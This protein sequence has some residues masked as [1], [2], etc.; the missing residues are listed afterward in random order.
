MENIILEKVLSFSTCIE[1]LEEIYFKDSLDY[2]LND[3]G[4][5]AL[6]IIK[7]NGKIKTM[8]GLENFEDTIDVDIYAPFEQIIEKEKFALRIEKMDHQII[9][10][11]LIL[12]ITLSIDGFKR[13]SENVE[14]ATLQDFNMTNE[15]ENIDLETPLYDNEILS[16]FQKEEENMPVHIKEEPEN[17]EM[18]VQ[19]E[20]VKVVDEKANDI[21][22]EDI[23]PKRQEIGKEEQINSN[24]A[25][26]LFQLNNSYVLFYRIHR[27]EDGESDAEQKFVVIHNKEQ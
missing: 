16:E 5:S 23:Q 27:H 10:N 1:K 13:E 26:D 6:G 2:K 7:I 12:K 3:D 8:K 4:V 14:E 15:I 9:R 21:C 24:W 18:A 11:N 17:V 19:E 20:T 22:E 25:N